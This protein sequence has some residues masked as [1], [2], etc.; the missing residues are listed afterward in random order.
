MPATKVKDETPKDVPHV[1][2][3]IYINNVQ[4]GNLDN[5]ITVRGI[6]KSVG[7]VAT[8]IKSSDQNRPSTAT[9]VKDGELFVNSLP[10]GTYAITFGLWVES[11][12]TPDFKF[13]ING[14]GTLSGDYSYMSF[15]ANM[16]NTRALGV[17]TGIGTDGN[18]QYLELHARII[19]TATSSIELLWSQN[20]SDPGDTKL[21]QGS[22]MELR[23]MENSA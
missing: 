7:I 12:I 8:I 22:S 5:K 1:D 17:E 18:V 11:G 23:Q 9:P 10:P 21:L 16:Q 4:G 19:I 2:D 6:G 14:D 13:T 20:A 3:E 15:S